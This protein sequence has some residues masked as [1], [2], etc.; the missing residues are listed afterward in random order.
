MI[1]GRL[2]R[3]LLGP[4]G[5]G[6]LAETRNG[7]FV[8]DPD[9]F[10]V[11]RKLLRDGAYDLPEAQF[12]SGLVRRDSTLVFVGAH[13]GALLV[14][15]VLQSQARA[16][17][18]LEPSPHNF[19]RLMLNLRLNELTHVRALR[20]A[21]GAEV[22]TLRFRENPINRG[23]SRIDPGGD[24]EVKVTPLDHVL[25][26]PVD[27]MVMDIEGSEVDAFRGAREALRHTENLY[28]E[29]APEQ[30]DE[31]GT[32]PAEFVAI[33]REYFPYAFRVDHRGAEQ[34]PED[35]PR[36]LLDLPP[37]RGLLMNLLLR[38]RALKEERAPIPARTLKA[39]E[40]I[41]GTL[42]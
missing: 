38:K 7:L 31:Q 6:V 39:P 1:R 23:N 42:K 20:M 35:Y 8:A 2:R 22:A 24:L 19:R 13:I 17:L 18:A 10:N 14:P 12:L 32:G 34:L 41:A 11:S 21:V 40:D 27:L 16:V 29:F 33:V 30:L 15:I 5:L 26:G 25:D 3:R 36:W 37:R 28:V 4:Y 9:D